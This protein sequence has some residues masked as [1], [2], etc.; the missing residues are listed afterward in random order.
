MPAYAVVQGLIRQ[1]LSKP[2]E[3]LKTLTIILERHPALV[4]S[5]D[6]RTGSSLLQMV[7]ENCNVTQVLE[8]TPTLTLTLTL[9]TRT[10]TRTRTRTLLAGGLA[11]RAG[12]GAGRARLDEGADGGRRPARLRHGHDR[13]RGLRAAW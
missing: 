4:N 2:E 6:P 10:R 5:H 13:G 1:M 9:L 3:L 12:R 11:A 7:T 8:R